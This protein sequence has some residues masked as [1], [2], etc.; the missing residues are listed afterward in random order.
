MWSE[1]Q[2]AADQTTNIQ[3]KDN[4]VILK[5]SLSSA[6]DPF[7]NVAGAESQKR[8]PA[9]SLQHLA[10]RLVSCANGAI[11]TREEHAN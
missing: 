6:F 9:Q 4:L 10:G 5:G 8:G 2:R 1:L 3:G 11:Q 7:F